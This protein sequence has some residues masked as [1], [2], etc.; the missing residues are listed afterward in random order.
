MKFTDSRICERLVSQEYV[1]YARPPPLHLSLSLSRIGKAA[2]DRKGR[3]IATATRGVASSPSVAITGSSSAHDVTW[4]P[5]KSRRSMKRST[6]DGPDHRVGDPT[7]RARARTCTR[8]HLGRAS[9][10]NLDGRL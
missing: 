9:G 8:M 1:F 6:R 5:A 7:V 4:R 10:G 3:R 2:S